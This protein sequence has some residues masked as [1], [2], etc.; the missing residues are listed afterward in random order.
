MQRL[1]PS[2]AECDR[3][4]LA[5]AHQIEEASLAWELAAS[6]PP[7]QDGGTELRSSFTALAPSVMPRGAN[8][9]LVAALVGG[10]VLGGAMGWK[11]TER[12]DAGPE[13][14]PTLMSASVQ[15][16]RTPVTAPASASSTSPTV[17]HDPPAPSLELPPPPGPEPMSELELLPATGASSHGGRIELLGQDDLASGEM[18]LRVRVVRDDKRHAKR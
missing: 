6:P 14:M 17:A 11:L 4:L 15:P 9:S 18:L 10:L 3:Q 16:T 1:Y 8:A 12:S 2:G 5:V 13:G 7:R